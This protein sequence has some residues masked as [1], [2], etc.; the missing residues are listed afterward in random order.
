VRSEV[1]VFV[2][3]TSARVTGEIQDKLILL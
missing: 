3:E 2:D 1:D